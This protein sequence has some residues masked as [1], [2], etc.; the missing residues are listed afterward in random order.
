[1]S[2]NITEEQLKRLSLAALAAGHVFAIRPNSHG[3]DVPCI[4]D[5]DA[6]WVHWSP[7]YDS[8][9]A[10][11]LASDIGINIEHVG[12]EN[13]PAQG[14]SCW[15]SNHGHMTVSGHYGS[16]KRGAVRRAIFE[17]AIL[18]GKSITEK[19]KIPKNG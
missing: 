3:V 14:V 12:M 6:D 19:T 4:M 17:A 11:D 9:D 13:K 18:L 10:L 2:N 1:M 15:P 7:E 16:D 8:G 5:S